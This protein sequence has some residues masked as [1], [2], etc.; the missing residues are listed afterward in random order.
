MQS[1]VKR[2]ARNPSQQAPL[3][4]DSSA[5]TASNEGKAEANKIMAWCKKNS[6]KWEDS[7]FPPN[8]KSLGSVSVSISEWKRP[9]EIVQNPDLFVDGVDEGDVVQGALGNCWFLSALSVLAQE[10]IKK[11]ESLFVCAQPKLGFYGLR[12]FKDNEWRVVFVDDRLPVKGGKPAFGGGQDPRE[13]WVALLEKA[14]A[15]LHGSY[16]AIE[17]GSIVDGLVDLTGEAGHTVKQL[18]PTKQFWNRLLLNQ[19][20]GFLMGCSS[21]HP[22][23]GA[24]SETAM[25]IL[26][27]HAYGI[28]VVKEVDG[29][30]LLRI[31]N[32]WGR[33]E[34]KGRW[35]DGAKEW[36]AKYR[37]AFNQVDADDGTF[38]ICFED[39]CRHF[40]S[41][42]LVRVLTTR[43]PY[44]RQRV[45]GRWSGKSAGGCINNSSWPNNPQYQICPNRRQNVY[46]S[47]R[48]SDKRYAKKSGKASSHSIGYMLFRS[49]G[50]LAAYPQQDAMVHMANFI[51]AR[52]YTEEIELQG[53]T[54]YVIIP[55]T[56]K[57]GVN[58]NF[59][60]TI[61]HSGVK[62]HNL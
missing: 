43:S 62:L 40:N 49:T 52:E 24:E 5:K 10:G 46:I 26:L 8:R 54:N 55:C 41:L 39:F 13:F 36:N 30:K 22:S 42:Y 34:W 7:S 18:E 23:A 27:N 47:V 2:F 61:Y 19:K 31:R 29:H 25:G 44:D 4:V 60:I 32:P 20:E 59:F 33:R 28:L 53:N 6:R 1:R 48:Q 16:G 37:R 51:D 11:I 21:T 56:F 50:R 15:K 3:R 57:S 9:C 14:Y 35:S 12:F 17:S 58:D 45:A 38:H